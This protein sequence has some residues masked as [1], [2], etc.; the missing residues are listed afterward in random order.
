MGRGEL[1][2][3]LSLASSRRHPL[4]LVFILPLACILSP[5]FILSLAPSVPGI[6]PIPGIHPVAR[7]HSLVGVHPLGGILW[8]W[9]PYCC[10]HH[11]SLAFILLLG[12]SLGGIHLL[13]GIHNLIRFLGEGNV[14]LQEINSLLFYS[15]LQTAI[16]IDII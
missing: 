9:H 1:A 8:R 15:M 10:W 2:F 7:I 12:P 14:V 3:I 6:H 11:L 16:Y 4:L 13:G 5:A